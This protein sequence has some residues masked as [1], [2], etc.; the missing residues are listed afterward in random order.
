[1]ATGTTGHGGAGSYSLELDGAHAGVLAA[2][3]SGSGL[4]HILHL[5]AMAGRSDDSFDA[6]T[7]A[8]PF[9]LTCGA[10][11]SRS[12]YQWMKDSFEGKGV[13]KNGAIVATD[14]SGTPQGRMTFTNALIT[15][16]HMPALDGASKDA[17]YMTITFMP[18]FTRQKSTH[19]TSAPISS[20]PGA[21]KQWLPSNFR[22][23]IAGLEQDCTAVSK[24]EALAVEPNQAG[25]INL[26]VYLTEARAK[27]FF[28][29]HDDFVVKGSS[30][31]EKS[32]TLEYLSSDMSQALF[33][34]SFD[35]LGIFKMTVNKMESAS[36][37]IR[38]VKAEMYC[39][40]MH[41]DYS[42]AWG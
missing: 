6:L 40:K 7:P 25:K 41:F 1:M 15:E 31:A 28:Q 9:V 11:M 22:L 30:Q 2:V 33:T 37:N 4:P 21:Q 13:R 32:G 14:L 24:I 36:E 42:G 10:G 8:Q 38:H 29:W 39:E 17:A 19:D 12:C 18:D 27:G 16:V 3:E 34:I 26:V 20:S 35:H 5:A 23:K